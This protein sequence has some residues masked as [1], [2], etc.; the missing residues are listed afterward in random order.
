MVF[1]ILRFIMKFQKILSRIYRKKKKNCCPTNKFFLLQPYLFS[2]IIPHIKIDS[3]VNRNF[4]KNKL[5]ANQITEMKDV[6]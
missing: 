1:E 6:L 4:V 2:R 5:L 3:L